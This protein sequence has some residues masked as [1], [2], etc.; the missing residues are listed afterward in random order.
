MSRKSTAALFLLIIS[1]IIIYLVWPSDEARI[2]KLVKETSAAVEKEDV[3]GVMSAISFNYR[4]KYGMSYLLLKKAFER[5]FR[6]LSDIEVEYED[7]RIEV[8]DKRATA[9]MDVRVIAS[10]SVGRGYVYGDLKEPL[11][12]KLDLEKEGG[13]KKWKVT[14]ATGYAGNSGDVF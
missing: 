6:V 7:L 13:M 2:K 4:D 1:P 10:I 14:G 12:L 9:S 8:E 3:A 11:R 5:E